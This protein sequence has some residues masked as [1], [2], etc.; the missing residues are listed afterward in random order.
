M[1]ISPHVPFV[2]SFS[3]SL[4][5]FSLPCLTPR[6]AYSVS[7]LT[8]IHTV[9]PQLHLLYANRAHTFSEMTDDKFPLSGLFLTEGAP[10]KDRLFLFWSTALPFTSHVWQISG[11]NNMKS[12]SIFNGYAVM[13]FCPFHTYIHPCIHKADCAAMETNLQILSSSLFAT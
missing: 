5:L 11:Q 13:E 10:N 6:S 3:L 2:T 4:K 8:K 1:I 12:Y 7:S 9:M